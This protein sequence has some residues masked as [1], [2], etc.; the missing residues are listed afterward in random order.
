MADEATLEDTQ[1]APTL[2]DGERGESGATGPE[3]GSP[4][5]SSTPPAEPVVAGPWIKEDGSFVQDW[6]QHLP[7]DVKQ[8]ATQMKLGERV[9]S[10]ADLA[11][12]TVNSQRLIGKKGVIPPTEKSTPEEIS[13][14]RKALGVPESIEGYQVK[15][16]KLPEG[17]EWSDADA[18]PFLEIAHKYHAPPGLMKEL[19]AAHV[20][21]QAQLAERMNYA[22]GQILQQKYDQ[23]IA[24]LNHAWGKKF[25]VNR[26]RV[27]EACIAKGCPTD[28]PG[29][30]SPNI[31]KLILNLRDDI[32]DSRF[33]AASGGGGGGAGTGDPEA[34]ANDIIFN[35]EN[36]LYSRYHAQDPQ[37]TS[38]V[39]G[40]FKE[41]SRLRN[42]R[43]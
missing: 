14:Y 4:P 11:R 10:V 5:T 34:I 3:T 13:E 26:R 27:E 37:I 2:L 35:K 17:I 40:L 43:K 33:V 38:Q 21:R 15:P 12:F 36:P 24:E 41:A 16:E 6:T 31:V 19:V 28:D 9:K 39:E 30:L 1:A 8:E 32:S 7:D 22:Q 18:K 42:L 20:N 23:G 29:L 25:E